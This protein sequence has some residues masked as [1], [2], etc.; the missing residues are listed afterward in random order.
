MTRD[1]ARHDDVAGTLRNEGWQC[2]MHP[3]HDPEHVRR[4][5]LGHPLRR[6]LPPAIG[7]IQTCVGKEDV[8]PA[9]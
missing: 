9:E 3:V 7:E 2:G 8:E 5:D 6:H 4:D 1:R